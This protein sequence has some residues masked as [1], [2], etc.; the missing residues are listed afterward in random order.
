MSATHASA[1]TDANANR[2]CEGCGLRPATHN[3]DEYGRGDCAERYAAHHE[4]AADVA[5]K[6]RGALAYGRDL[7]LDD[8]WLKIALDDVREELSC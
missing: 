8:D 5:A 7:G 4:K 1:Q 2:L 6:M 3:L